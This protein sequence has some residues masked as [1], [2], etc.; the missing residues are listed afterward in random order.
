MWNALPEWMNVLFFS[1][2]FVTLVA[3]I[4]DSLGSLSMM[5]SDVWET[6]K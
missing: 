4:W 2:F 6:Q 5:V 1:P 3:N